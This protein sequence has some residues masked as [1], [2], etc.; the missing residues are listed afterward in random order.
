MIEVLKDEV[1]VKEIIF[2]A[3]ME[4]EVELDVVLTPEL[5]EEGELREL[6]RKIQKRQKSL[7]QEAGL[8]LTIIKT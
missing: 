5:K 7:D 3:K 2:D 1:N 8:M 4:K 6:L